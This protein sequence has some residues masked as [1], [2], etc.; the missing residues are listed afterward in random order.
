VIITAMRTSSLTC[1]SSTLKS[2][3]FKTN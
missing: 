2:W 1:C 3:W